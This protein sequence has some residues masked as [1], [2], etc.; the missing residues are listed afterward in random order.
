MQPGDVC[1]IYT[2]ENHPEWCGF[3][4]GSGSAIWNNSGDTATLKDGNGTLIDE[5]GYKDIREIKGQ[6]HV[7]RAL[8][9]ALFHVWD[10]TPGALSCS[11]S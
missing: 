6:E 1:R 7:K 3:N 9:V 8:E 5:Y 4:Y 11:F 10:N 2:N